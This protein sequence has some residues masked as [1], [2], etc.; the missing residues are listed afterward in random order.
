MKTSLL[1]VGVRGR[2]DMGGC[3]CGCAGVGVSQFGTVSSCVYV[4]A[5]WACG[6]VGLLKFSFIYILCSNL[7]VFLR[8]NNT[9]HNTIYIGHRMP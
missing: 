8:I 9:R 7:F 3:E 1:A 4:W 2:A 5:V 6:R